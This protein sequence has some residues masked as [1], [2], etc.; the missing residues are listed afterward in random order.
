MNPEEGLNRELKEEIDLEDRFAVVSGDYLYSS[1]N[2]KSG[3]V[4]HFYAKE[5]SLDDFVRIEKHSLESSD[6]GGEVFG[7]LRPPLFETDKGSDKG[8]VKFMRNQFVGNSLIQLLRT[9][10]H[11]DILPFNQ[12]IYFLDKF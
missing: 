4:L 3:I 1:V 8:F 7:V 2:H 9:I 10:H 6:Y 12:L 11:F 5:V